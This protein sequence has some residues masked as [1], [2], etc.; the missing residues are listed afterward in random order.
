[1]VEL[2]KDFLAIKG[3]VWKGEYYNNQTCQYEM[4]GS[5]GDIRTD[6]TSLPVLKIYE[7]GHAQYVT[8]NLTEDKFQRFAEKYDVQDNGMS[9]YLDEDY[10]E[11]WID[12]LDLSLGLRS[13]DNDLGEMGD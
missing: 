9:I 5:W 1:M 2:V 11:D 8:F 4:A 7:D 12:F 10:S 13:G 6:L 3:I